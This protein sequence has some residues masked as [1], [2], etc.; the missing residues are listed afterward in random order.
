MIG[1]VT[2]AMDKASKD[3]NT[4]FGGYDS[5]KFEL[6]IL[7]STYSTT[8]GKGFHLRVRVGGKRETLKGSCGE[9]DVIGITLDLNNGTVSCTINDEERGDV[10]EGLPKN[11]TYRLAASLTRTGTTL[12]I[13]SYEKLTCTTNHRI[14]AHQA[15]RDCRDRILTRYRAEIQRARKNEIMQDEDVDFDSARCAKLERYLKSKVVSPKL[16]RTEEVAM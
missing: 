15:T 13:A 10:Y 1:L 3:I 5:K 12:R 11:E 7:R 16:G 14:P 8:F 2:G 9:G 6:A 4:F